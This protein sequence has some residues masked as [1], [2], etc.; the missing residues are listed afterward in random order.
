MVRHHK[1][2]KKLSRRGRM[3][4]G[5]WY[6]PRTWFSKPAQAATTG[7]DQTVQSTAQASAPL[8]DAIT[9]PVTDM[10]GAQPGGTTAAAAPILGP[11]ASMG[12][13][14]RRTRKHKRRHSR[15]H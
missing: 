15:R 3:R 4:G 8:G 14:R 7:I 2:T 13:R 11:T 6:D 9:Q 12:G 5:A 10:T 1:K